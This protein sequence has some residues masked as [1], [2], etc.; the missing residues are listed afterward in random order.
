M[1]EYLANALALG[2][3]ISVPIG[4][5]SLLC[6]QRTL[7]SGRTAGFATGLGIAVAD[8]TY[9][10]AVAVGFRISEYAQVMSS[11]WA[12]F[13]IGS[14]VVFV[15][16]KIFFVSQ[17]K[18]AKDASYNTLKWCTLSGFFLTLLN[19]AAILLLIAGFAVLGL[20]DAII[21]FGR[22]ILLIGGIFV[23]SMFWWIILV[24]AVSAV[25]RQV[26]LIALRAINQLTGVVFIVFGIL[27]IGKNYF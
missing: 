1:F 10:V 25:K 15:G 7:T 8:A 20:A 13:I 14:L 23:G 4:P 26:P 2:F 16:L 18:T 12:N 3:G 9:A 17:I 22:G 6:M 19:P 11:P 5:V 27:V 21:S 24:F